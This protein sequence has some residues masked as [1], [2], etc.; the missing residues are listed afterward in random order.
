MQTL[1]FADLNEEVVSG[2]F[3]CQCNTFA[4]STPAINTL[5]FGLAYAGKQ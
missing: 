2:S 5:T 3:W 4:C 1:S